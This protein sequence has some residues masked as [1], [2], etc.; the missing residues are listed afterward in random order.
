MYFERLYDRHLAQA[1]YLIGCQK[2]GEAIVVDPERDIDR[3]LKAAELNGLRIVSITETHIHADYLSGARE[4]AEKTGATLYLSDEG[5]EDWAYRW[6]GSKSDGGEYKHHLLADGDSFNVGNVE[7]RA[8]HTPGHT[9]EHLS[10]F[11][12]DHGGGADEPIGVLSGDFVFVGDVGR[13]DLLENAAGEVGTAEP[14]AHELYD[15]LRWFDRLDPWLQV[16]PGHGAGSACG[17][18]LGAIPSSTVG[19]EQ[20][21]NNPLKL[22]R[23][24]AGPFV[25]DILSGQTDPPLYFARMKKEN[26]E[27][28]ALLGELPVPA[29]MSAVDLRKGLEAGGQVFD[30]RPWSEYR[31][32]H[33]RGSYHTPLNQSFA[34]IAGSYGE[35]ARKIFLVLPSGVEAEEIARIL[36]RVGVDRV[37]GY[38]PADEL[39]VYLSVNEAERSE[40]RTATTE[41]LAATLREKDITILD[42]RGEAEYN[43]AHVNGALQLAHSRLPA[44]LPNLPD[45]MLYVHCKSG[46]RSA[47]ASAYLQAH[48]KEVTYVG[49]AF[50]DFEGAGLPIVTTPT[51]PVAG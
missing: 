21:Y 35:P 48:G 14:A 28:P 4:L 40:I 41:G 19:Y 37:V 24:E 38:L 12:F 32:S 44:G 5:G 49:G 23:G 26:R 16:W 50:A 13:P 17:K 18:S 7:L 1:S 39:A 20:R 11:L 15:S 29:K 22:S 6:I 36:V 43:E 8:F 33:L 2:T 47:V 31:V 25:E 45:G 9:P 27:G 30:L 46:A 34:T 42:V 3:Y 10:F 51:E